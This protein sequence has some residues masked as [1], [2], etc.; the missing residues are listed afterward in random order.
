MWQE[1]TRQDWTAMESEANGRNHETIFK[2]GRA[3]NRWSL[4]CCSMRVLHLYIVNIVSPSQEKHKLWCTYSQAIWSV[5]R[6]CDTRRHDNS[7][8]SHWSLREWWYCC[9]V[10]DSQV[11]WKSSID[12]DND[13]DFT[14]YADKTNLDFPSQPI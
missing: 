2:N 4:L 1:V 11:Q 12:E 14:D 3:G 13:N 5:P 7:R 8:L 9:P 6:P 10:Q